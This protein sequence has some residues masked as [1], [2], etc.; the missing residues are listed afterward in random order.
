M[1]QENLVDQQHK[2]LSLALRGIRDELARLTGNPLMPIPASSV[3]VVNIDFDLNAI[4]IEFQT[5]NTLLKS[6]IEVLAKQNSVTVAIPDIPAIPTPEAR[7]KILGL[8]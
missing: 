2:E 5:L 4:A 7:K 3:P 6:L 8:F 1:H